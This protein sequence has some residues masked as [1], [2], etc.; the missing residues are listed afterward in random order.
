[1]KQRTKALGTL[2]AALLLLLTVLTSCASATPL[3]SKTDGTRTY[4]V[5]GGS[6]PKRIQVSENGTVVWKTRVSVDKTVGAQNGSYGL[7]ILDLNFDGL[8]DIKLI[9][10]V[11]GSV[12]TN[13]CYLQTANGSYEYSDELSRLCNVGV[14]AEQK[15]IFSFAHT[16]SADDVEYSDAK[17]SHTWSDITTA[18]VWENG[19]LK[20][21]RRVWL[22]YYSE[23][24]VY[25]YSI[26]DYSDLTEEFLDPDD[27]WMTPAEYQKT[28]FG[29]LYYF[30]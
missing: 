5:H 3:Y 29:F 13:A 18:H 22:T 2:L 8:S 28:D 15:V 11:N 30:R 19:A 25:C 7:E 17:P 20:P 26:S 4:A 21:Y 14:D 23:H 16:Y 27:T 24:D 12:M 9:T 1:M 10:S 6:R